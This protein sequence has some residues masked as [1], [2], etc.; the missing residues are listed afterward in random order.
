MTPPSDPK[1]LLVWKG[2]PQSLVDPPVCD[3]EALAAYSDSLTDSERRL[4]GHLGSYPLYARL[5]AA[6]KATT[7]ADAA[8]ALLSK[9]VSRF[10]LEGNLPQSRLW[11]VQHNRPNRAQRRAKR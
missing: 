10:M 7:P 2:G 3:Q 9:E 8:W 5:R 1:Y 6:M 4:L 11:L